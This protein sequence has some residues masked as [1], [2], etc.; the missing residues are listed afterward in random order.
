M[1]NTTLAFVVKV[2]PSVASIYKTVE[3]RASYHMGYKR[4]EVGTV[5]VSSSLGPNVCGHTLPPKLKIAN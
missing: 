2:H 5:G 4:V 3:P 1:K